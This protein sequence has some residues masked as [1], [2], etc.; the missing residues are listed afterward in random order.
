MRK[1]I[2]L[3]LALLLLMPGASGLGE[4]FFS[5]SASEEE[6]GAGET[7]VATETSPEQETRAWTY[8][9]S[10]E[11]LDDPMD[12]ILNVNRDNL[13]EKD[14]PPKDDLHTLVDAT[15]KKKSSSEML[16]RE[17]ANEAMVEMFAAAEA[18]G[19]G[20]ILFSAYRSYQTQA[21]M[22]EVR[23]E[24][25]GKDDGLVQKPGASDHQTGL[26]FDILNANW[27]KADGFNKRFAQEKEAV[28]MEENCARFGFIIRYPQGKEDITG[29]AYEPWH[30]RYVGREVAAYI[31]ERG[32][33]LEE[34]TAEWR[35][36]VAEYELGVAGGQQETEAVVNSFS[37]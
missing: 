27:L 4:S 16:A 37:F 9:I 18:E 20:L 24:R 34:F 10:R 3:I 19:L 25:L 30:L 11:L 15:V 13:L 33:T 1:K 7:A 5:F 35:Q 12:V 6:T 17:V 26:G 28:W 31:H 14:Y 23:L 36:A 21:T 2:S 22:Y 32:L 8:P 29:I